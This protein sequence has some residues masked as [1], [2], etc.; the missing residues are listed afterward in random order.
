MPAV[1]L[2]TRDV[3]VLRKPP[4]AVPS[5]R[6]PP[7]TQQRDDRSRASP[8]SSAV[9][10]PLS[11]TVTDST[12]RSGQAAWPQ[13]TWRR[14]AADG[15]SP[16]R[17]SGPSSR[18]SSA[19]TGSSPRS[20][21]PPTSNTR[22]SCRSSTRARPD[23]YLFYVMPYIE[24]RDAARPAQPGEAAP[25][26]RRGPHRTRGGRGA[27]LRPPPRRGPPRHQAGEHPAPRRPGAGGRLRHR[28]RG[29]QGERRADDRD[30]HVARHAALHEPRAGDGRAEITARSDVYA[31]GA[32]LYEMLTGEPPFTGNTAQAVVARVLTESPRPMATQ[33][34]TIRGTSRLRSLR[35]SRSCRPTA[36][37][38]RRSSPKPSRT[39]HT[40]ARCRWSAEWG[41][42]HACR[43][44]PSNGTV[45]GRWPRRR[46]SPRPSRRSGAGSGR[47]RRSRSPS[48][49]LLSAATRRSTRLRAA[50]AAELPLPPTGVRIVYAGPSEGGSKPS[51]G[52]LAR[53]ARGP[54][55]S[56][57]PGK[58]VSSPFSFR[59]MESGSVSSRNGESRCAFCLAGWCAP[60]TT[61]TD[62]ANSTAGDWG[63]DGYIYFE[64]D[65]GT[66]AHVAP[67]GAP[68][69]RST[70]V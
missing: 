55:P 32:V 68:S 62:K 31:L 29:Q 61:L 17:C 60:T 24:G 46:R 58:R 18:P 67:P 23:A 1:G 53:S 49:A 39:R 19:P 38:R 12:A 41:R 33:R 45:D 52:P 48:S 6:I 56:R 37:P 51:L 2:L 14:P 11:K 28:A 8:S 21:S 63:S 16:S 25:G 7:S 44:A 35:R 27:R 64:V 43:P 69:S 3:I 34:H 30:R 65:S 54:R 5:G 66:G 36:S 57:E 20:S 22:T 59:P 26:R 15:R 50:A 9:C 13:F 42:A 10:R 4:P 40:R 70:A 47:R